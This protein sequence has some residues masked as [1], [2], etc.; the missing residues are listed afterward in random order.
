MHTYD[1]VVSPGQTSAMETITAASTDD[2][3]RGPPASLVVTVVS[4]PLAVTA[5]TVTPGSI[6]EGQS[7]TASGT[8]TDT[9]PG[10]ADSV[11]FTWGDGTTSAGTVTG[12]TYTGTHTYLNQPAGV[13]QGAFQITAAVSS[14]TGAAGSA[15]ASV[16]VADVAPVISSLSKP[17]AINE[18]GAVT[19]TGAVTDPG[20]LDNETVQVVWGDG[21]TSAA[22]VN[23]TTRAFTATHTYLNN[24]AGE[25]TGGAF[26]I[27]ATATDDV[28]ETGSAATGAVVNNVPPSVVGLALSPT[29][30]GV[31]QPVT[32]TGK[33]TDPGILDGESAVV[34]WG[35]GT[36]SAATVDQTTRT[37]SAVHTYASIA[38]T[39][40]TLPITVTATDSDGGKGSA[41]TSITVT[42]AAPSLASLAFT[43]ASINEGS[44]T[45]LSGAISGLGALDPATVAVTWGDGATQTVS[46]AAGTTSFAISHIYLDNPAGEPVG[47]FTASATVT[48]S[49]SKLSASAAATVTVANVAPVITSF[50]DAS[51]PTSKAPAGVP[52]SYS[53]AF[54]DPGALDTHTVTIGW[55]DGTKASVY[56]LPAGQLT[57]APTHTYAKAG[58]YYVTVALVDKDGG[59]A[60][61]KAAFAYIG[62]PPVMAVGAAAPAVTAGAAAIP[63][64]VAPAPA[65]AASAPVSGP[66][67]PAPAAKPAAAAAT[68]PSSA[69][70]AGSPVLAALAIDLPADDVIRLVRSSAIRITDQTPVAPSLPAPQ[71]LDD[72]DG[73]LADGPLPGLVEPT[74]IA[75][76]LGPEQDWIMLG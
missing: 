59:A 25:P 22:T 27:T 14:S 64:S 51:S 66:P 73:S 34:T 46:L 11:L 47:T 48:D 57:F 56:T 32:L 65:E 58:S 54:T 45:V 17:A 28:G 49:L 9:I 24:P 2:V 8:F 10:A 37:F 50:T 18:G 15:S 60:P 35:D 39:S 33:I 7:V 20:V 1:G 5:P 29:A 40:Q 44:S 36:T 68:R 4:L 31:G 70:S 69:G 6:D 43:P 53:L 61:S 74:M 30:A 76:N 62:A 12:D 55:G 13:T 19:V 21:S 38:G 23:E 72:E 75:W 63:A 16:T 42:A 3:G 71:L 26:A 52:L 41:S 67:A